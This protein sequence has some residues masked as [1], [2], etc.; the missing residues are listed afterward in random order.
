MSVRKP[1]LALLMSGADGTESVGLWVVAASD[2]Y[3]RGAY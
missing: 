3:Q 2:N 1:S